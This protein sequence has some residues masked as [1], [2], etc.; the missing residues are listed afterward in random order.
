MGLCMNQ[1]VTAGS[2]EEKPL[3]QRGSLSAEDDWPWPARSDGS[4]WEKCK[5]LNTESKS[6][7]R[8]TLER[9][10]RQVDLL[11]FGLIR[12]FW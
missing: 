10:E 5:V 9:Y 12:S 6:S 4:E 3:L 2:Y 11:C 7:E 8:D 1:T